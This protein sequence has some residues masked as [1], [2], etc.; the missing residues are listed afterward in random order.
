MLS[1]AIC[2]TALDVRRRSRKCRAKYSYN[3]LNCTERAAIG[4]LTEAY[5][6]MYLQ[7]AFLSDTF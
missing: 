1:I 6:L 2:A 5:S 7:S 3:F 4:I